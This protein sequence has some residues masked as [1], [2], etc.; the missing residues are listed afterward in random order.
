MHAPTLLIVEDEDPLRQA[1]SKMLGKHGFHVIETSD[2]SAALDVLRACTNPLQVMF[3]DITIPGASAREVLLEARRLR[4]ELK[5]IVT[6]AYPEE[7][8]RSFLQ[9]A[10]D[11]FIRK[12][13][14]IDHLMRLIDLTKS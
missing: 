8:A 6:S 12:P 10:I 9:S 5:V 1:V 14:Q 4:P 3:L 13:Y 11:H 2:G 7:M